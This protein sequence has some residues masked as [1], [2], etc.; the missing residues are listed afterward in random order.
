LGQ[1]GGKREQKILFLAPYARAQRRRECADAG[2]GAASVPPRRWG[3]LGR[4][5]VLI[6]QEPSFGGLAMAYLLLEAR[7]SL[8][9]VKIH[10]FMDFP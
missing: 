1:N 9:D 3:L 5:A 8:G 4:L 2:T 6:I 10:L 7:L